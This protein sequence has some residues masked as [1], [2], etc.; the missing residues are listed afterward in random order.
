MSEPASTASASE[1][2]SDFHLCLN[3][4]WKRFSPTV[5]T[6]LKHEVSTLGYVW[7]KLPTFTG[8]KGYWIRLAIPIRTGEA[9]ADPVHFIETAARELVELVR[10][11]VGDRGEL[12]G[13]GTL[14]VWGPNDRTYPSAFEEGDDCDGNGREHGMGMGPA[15]VLKVYAR[16]AAEPLNAELELLVGCEQLGD[17]VLPGEGSAP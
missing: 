12:L 10:A 3:A 4:A 15:I 14:L 17:L 13:L 16:R 6:L 7:P 8:W 9:E 2:L 5:V 11:K 1:A